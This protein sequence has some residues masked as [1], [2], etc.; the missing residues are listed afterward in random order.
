MYT[1]IEEYTHKL[2]LQKQILAE[3]DL[4]LAEVKEHSWLWQLINPLYRPV[5][6]TNQLIVFTYQGPVAQTLVDHLQKILALIDISNA[7]VL[8][9]TDDTEF[10]SKARNAQQHT[11]DT[12]AS[13]CQLVTFSSAI[14]SP[15][16]KTDFSV[17]DSIC[18]APWAKLEIRPDGTCK[19]CC[20]MAEPIKDADLRPMTVHDN[21]LEE[22]YHSDFL[23][24]LRQQ[25]RSG[26]K[27]SLCHR[28]WVDE[29]MDR[30]STRQHIDWDLRQERFNI[31]WDI[32]STKNL[33]SWQLS[34]GNTCNLKCRVCG[35]KFSSK[36][37]V[38]IL[39]NLDK[40]ASKA[41]ADYNRLK[42]ISWA[43]L[44]DLDIWTDIENTVDHISELR[45]TG[46]EPMLIKKQFEVM[47][48]MA[49]KPQAANINLHYTT[50]GTIDFPK[51]YRRDLTRFKSVSISLSIDDIGP[52]FEYQRSGACW[53]EVQENLKSYLDLKS[54]CP[55][56][57]L[58]VNTTVSIMNIFY[59]PEL[60][61]WYCDHHFDFLRL[62]V[63]QQPEVLAISRVT[64][65]FRAAC[66]ERLSSKVWPFDISSQLDPII[67][68]LDQA[69]PSDGVEFCDHMRLIDA[70]RK[71]NFADFHREVADLMG[72][73]L[74]SA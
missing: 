60:L 54:K 15:Q 49:A 14:S 37:A 52:R 56:L 55:T 62:C 48:Y 72:Y 69:E 20:V 6:D 29:S 1:T 2:K 50:N 74:H 36:W 42:K 59:L 34:L 12:F 11:T 4:N 28:C 61:D 64:E 40:R 63:L 22:I 43:E 31:D 46:G 67:K 33:H 35:P 21:S 16:N 71:E 68:H 18:L 24:N 10:E 19:P 25:L 8:V 53:S 3:V 73:R 30:K 17:P 51:D 23:R 32:E 70:R 13:P 5:F 39:N 45:F 47:R 65:D 58:K 38:E 9:L 41:S 7:F 26:Q 57:T 27:P 44:E 66:I